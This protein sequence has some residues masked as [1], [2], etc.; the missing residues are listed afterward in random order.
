MP[1]PNLKMTSVG[2]Q[3]GVLQV[4]F[5][6]CE[7]FSRFTEDVMLAHLL[8][9][10]NGF[11]ASTEPCEPAQVSHRVKPNCKDV[12]QTAVKRKRIQVYV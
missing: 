1:F 5:V 2:S 9:K 3:C 6:R 4:G 10:P 7:A 8:I 12:G 11:I